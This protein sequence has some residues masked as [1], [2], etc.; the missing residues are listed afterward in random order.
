M[1][2][3]SPSGDARAFAGHS[4]VQASVF[5]EDWMMRAICENRW[6][7]DDKTPNGL[8]WFQSFA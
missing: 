1:K 5:A 3:C 8:V 7:Q 4:T 2:L 6:P